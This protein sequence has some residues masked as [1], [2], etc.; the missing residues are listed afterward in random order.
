MALPVNRTL[1]V[2]EALPPSRRYVLPRV[3]GFLRELAEGFYDEFGVPLMV[4]SAVR[5]VT[6]QR[7]LRRINRNAA[8]IHGEAASSHEAGCTIDIARHRLTRAQLHWLELR[9]A[10][11]Q[12][13]RQLILVEEERSCFHVMVVSYFQL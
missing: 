2:S 5:P 6:V 7:R 4:D 11:Y 1:I 12:F 13:A 8:P 10:Y 3:N 9:L